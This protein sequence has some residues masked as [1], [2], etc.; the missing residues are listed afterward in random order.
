MQVSRFLAVKPFGG[1][2][3][4]GALECFPPL[5][6]METRDVAGSFQNFRSCHNAGLNV[7]VSMALGH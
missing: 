3:M 4:N 2:Y 5:P 7:S 1:R 6:L